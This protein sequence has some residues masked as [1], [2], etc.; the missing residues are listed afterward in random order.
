MVS[1]FLFGLENL[2]EKT[3]FYRLVTQRNTTDGQ[4]L[5]NRFLCSRLCDLCG[6]IFFLGLSI[7]LLEAQLKSLNRRERRGRGER[8]FCFLFL[9]PILFS[10]LS[11]VSAVKFFFY[12]FSTAS[13]A[14]SHLC[15]SSVSV[16]LTVHEY[17]KVGTGQ[18][19]VPTRI[20]RVLRNISYYDIARYAV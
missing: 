3:R 17:G 18:A 14:V 10:A 4:P 9:I 13:L 20:N 7:G 1:L 15:P 5:R 11:A 6:K 2:A 16:R 19:H 8:I 12:G